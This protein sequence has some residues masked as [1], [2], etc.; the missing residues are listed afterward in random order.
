[1]KDT[2]VNL[3]NLL[4]KLD[5]TA[6]YTI[7]EYTMTEIQ[8]ITEKAIFIIKEHKSESESIDKLNGAIKLSDKFHKENS[9]K[10]IDNI[11]IVLRSA[12]F[13]IESFLHKEF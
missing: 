10:K 7:G 4:E 5:R 13:A 3:M 8:K 9:Y 6:I 11:M 2:E 1:M 12:K